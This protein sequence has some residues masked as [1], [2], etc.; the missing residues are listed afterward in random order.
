MPDVGATYLT[1]A[2]LVVITP[3]PDLAVV[4]KNGL[5]RNG[6]NRRVAVWT[7]L[8]VVVSLLTQ[9]AVVA[10]GIAAVILSST[11]AFNVIKYAGTAYMIF[12]GVQSLRSALKK[13][14]NA[15]D[16]AEPGSNDRQTE[17]RGFGQGLVSNITNPKVLLFYI[18]VLP[19]FVDP[20]ANPIPQVVILAALHAGI[21]LLWLMLAIFAL[22]KIERL[23]S[24]SVG[25][26]IIEAV[27][28]V[29]LI[30]FGCG[31]AFLGS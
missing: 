31:L 7:S 5:N 14:G 4:L 26:R 17:I 23:L 15:D 27:L 19:Q 9:G 18:S 25:R 21:A 6:M 24:S 29:C 30:G 11:I 22:S 1:I 2:V 13:E 16:K 28:G 12:L 3:G 10:F 8:G 20:A